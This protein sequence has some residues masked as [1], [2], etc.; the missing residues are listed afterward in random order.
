MRGR[1]RAC[2][3]CASADR[4]ALR[5]DA[6]TR[7]ALTGLSA[8]TQRQQPVATQATCSSFQLPVSRSRERATPRSKRTHCSVGALTPPL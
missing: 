7:A 3:Q 6:C 1:N 8:T 5:T 4:R 2:S